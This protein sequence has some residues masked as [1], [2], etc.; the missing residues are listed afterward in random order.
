MAHPLPQ[1]LWKWHFG[2]LTFFKTGPNITSTK[3]QAECAPSSLFSFVFE[4]TSGQQLK[5]LHW[6]AITLPLSSCSPILLCCAMVLLLAGAGVMAARNVWDSA[7]KC[8]FLF[9]LVFL[10]FQPSFRKA[11]ED[12]MSGRAKTHIPALWAAFLS[13]LSHSVSQKQLFL[14]PSQPHLKPSLRVSL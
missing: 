2:L 12:E 8:V 10:A 5:K 7:L 13:P 3:Y 11:V 4:C 9:C 6:C 1:V 14:T